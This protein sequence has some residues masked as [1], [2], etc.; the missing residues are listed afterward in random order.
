MAEIKY[1]KIYDYIKEEILN[2]HLLPNQ[3]LPKEEWF[4]EQF[5]V[6]YL[7]Y[8]K[9]MKQNFSNIPLSKHQTLIT[10]I[11]PCLSTLIIFIILSD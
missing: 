8:N 5:N 4:E 11:A 10:R 9:A 6:S 2:G 1:K 7:T 3:R